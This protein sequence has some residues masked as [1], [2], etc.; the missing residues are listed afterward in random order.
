M[1][2]LSTCVYACAQKTTHSHSNLNLY[3]QIIIF[4]KFLK[5]FEIIKIF[6]MLKNVV[7]WTLTIYV[8]PNFVGFAL[9]L[10]VSEICAIFFNVFDKFEILKK[11]WNFWNVQKCFTVIIGNSCDP[12]ISSVSLY[13]LRF[14]SLKN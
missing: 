10:T 6:E 12:Q 14:L 2:H 3:Y 13:L 1:S 9:S 5:C 8:I 7:L 4:F 11:N